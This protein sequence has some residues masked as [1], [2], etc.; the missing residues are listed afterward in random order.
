MSI[1]CGRDTRLGRISNVRSVGIDIAKSNY[2]AVALAIDGIPRSSSVWSPKDKRDS[3]AARLE[4]YYLWVMRKLLLYRADV[5]AVEKLE[6]FQNKNTIRA[7]SNHEGVA[8]LAAKQRKAI[9]LN[10]GVSQARGVVFG[11]GRLSKDDAWGFFRKMYPDLE[12]RGKNAGGTDQMDAF[13]H[14]LAAPTIL[15]RR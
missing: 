6:V 3:T 12:L 11:N 15:E 14:A 4:D 10:P 8:L 13:T 9:V 5:V 7:M 2:A 1:A